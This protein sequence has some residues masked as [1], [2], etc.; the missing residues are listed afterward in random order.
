MILINIVGVYY[1]SNIFDTIGY[2]YTI[3]V[4]VD[5]IRSNCIHKLYINGRVGFNLDGIDVYDIIGY[6]LYAIDLITLEIKSIL[7]CERQ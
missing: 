3:W 4:I 6:N 5:A 2:T 1:I 7:Y